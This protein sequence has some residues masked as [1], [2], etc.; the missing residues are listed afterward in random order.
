M[1]EQA[2]GAH[3]EN[4]SSLQYVVPK[5]CLDVTDLVTASSLNA[6][7]GTGRFVSANEAAEELGLALLGSPY[8]QPEWV[9]V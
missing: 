1:F 9:P 8:T 6:M 2:H 3:A 7:S 5:T 4:V